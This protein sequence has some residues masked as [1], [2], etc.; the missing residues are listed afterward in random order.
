MTAI[1][2]IRVYPSWKREAIEEAEKRGQSLSQFIYD[3]M[4]VGWGKLVDDDVKQNFKI[5]EK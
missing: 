3:C 4:E 5:N 2:A 1:I